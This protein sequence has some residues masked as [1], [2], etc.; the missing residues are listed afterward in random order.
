MLHNGCL[1]H[2]LQKGALHRL[3]QLVGIKRCVCCRQQRD[4]TEKN[5]KEEVY[6]EVHVDCLSD[7]SR[8]WPINAMCHRREMQASCVPG[9]Q[10]SGISGLRMGLFLQQTETFSAVG[11]RADQSETRCGTAI[12]SRTT[13]GFAAVYGKQHWGVQAPLMA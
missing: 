7:R 11:R 12:M 9:A 13:R 5:E 3:D 6:E 2:L 8:P 1:S 10:K 4:A